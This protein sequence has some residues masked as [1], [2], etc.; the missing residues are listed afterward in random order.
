MATAEDGV[1]G[2][3]SL[4]LGELHSTSGLQLDH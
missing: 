2:Y 1:Y 4:G 3:Y